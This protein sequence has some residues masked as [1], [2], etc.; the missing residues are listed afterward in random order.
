M[1]L[2]MGRQKPEIVRLLQSDPLNNDLQNELE[3]WKAEQQNVLERLASSKREIEHLK[4][5][6]AKTSQYSSLLCILEALSVYMPLKT[7]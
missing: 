2:E 5:E 1:T 7:N 4:L 3:A 6:A